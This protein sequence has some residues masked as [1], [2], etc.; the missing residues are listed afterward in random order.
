MSTPLTRRPRRRVDGVLLLDKPQGRSSNA[1]LQHA[2]WV[3]AAEKAGH[4]GTLDPLAS[5]LLPICFGE[6]TKFAQSLLDARKAYIATVQFGVATTTGDAEGDVTSQ[7]PVEFTRGDLERTLPHFVGTQAQLPPRHSA[8]KFQGR[9]YYEYARAGIEIPRVAREVTV[10]EI[11]LVD[12]TPPTAT[13]RVACGKGT[14]IRTLAEDIAVALGT[15]AHLSALRRTLTGPFTLEHAVRLDA[16]ETMDSAKRDALLLPAH[17]P[18]AEM[19]RLD[20]DRQAARALRE[21][22][23]G[24]VPGAAAGRYCCFEAGG[25]FLGIVEVDTAGIRAIRLVRTTPIPAG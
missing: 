11:A 7:M 24:P 23:L 25:G 15:C 18:L 3:F 8:L 13:L 16:L 2:K 5:G 22:R 4:T 1:A 6:A 9:N 17:A 14:Y 20:V 21:G 19:E 12:W 10:H